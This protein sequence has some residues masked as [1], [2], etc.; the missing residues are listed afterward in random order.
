MK[1][2]YKSQ[3]PK[4]EAEVRADLN[5]WLAAKEAHKQTVGVPAPFP[6]YELLNYLES[7]FIVLDDNEPVP[8]T[9]EQIADRERTLVLKELE[10][11]DIES[12]RSIREYIASKPDAPQI[13]K[14][15]EAKAIAE[16]EKLDK[17][18]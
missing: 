1:I 11:I 9:P 14:D 15:K 4:P 12:I 10:R 8:E 3:L 18:K 16:R 6:E 7:D 13:L 2:I 17:P 5:A